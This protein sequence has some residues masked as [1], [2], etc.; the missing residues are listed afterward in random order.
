[1]FLRCLLLFSSLSLLIGFCKLGA[2][3]FFKR[4]YAK[5]FQNEIVFE[6]TK[7]ELPRL[8][9]SATLILTD[10]N[11]LRSYLLSIHSYLFRFNVRNLFGTISFLNA[12]NT[13]NQKIKT[14][15]IPT[16]FFS[17]KFRGSIFRQSSNNKA[18]SP[19]EIYHEKQ[20]R[21]L[22]AVHCLNNLF[23]SKFLASF[24]RVFD[25]AMILFENS[26]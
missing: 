24:W 8:K 1:M 14:N 10:S 18:M 2:L 20:S 22:C 3:K 21:M 6:L 26:H 19:P 7:W 16:K 4:F 13:S 15:E 5:N 12:I 23:Q 17:P 11:F 9:I 25:F